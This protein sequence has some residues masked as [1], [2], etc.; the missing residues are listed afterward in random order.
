MQ[1]PA[2]TAVAFFPISVMRLSIVSET[3]QRVW[4]PGVDLQ[5]VI[6]PATNHVVTTGATFY[7]DRSSDRRLTTTTTSMVGQVVL[8]AR[9]PAA[10]VFP[11]PVR[12]A[13]P[14]WPGRCACPTRPSATSPSS[15]R[16]NGAWRRACRSSAA[17]AA[18]STTSRTENT[19]G[20]DLAPVVAGAVPAIDPATLP[21]V[22][23]ESITRRA[24][25]G[26]IGIVAIP[27]GR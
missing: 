17:C 1:F 7:R 26:D 20:Y 9:G 14:R 15:R 11:S 27:A 5:A 12:S 22:N 4:T 13:R 18:T 3:E 21:D 24:L 6:T 8:G 19:P 2:P 25:T 23:G 10:V 16:T